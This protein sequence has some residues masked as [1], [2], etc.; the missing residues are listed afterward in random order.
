MDGF[1]NEVR[2]V[3]R[4]EVKARASRT[5]LRDLRARLHDLSAPR[6]FRQ[7]LV[8]TAGTR[9]IA[10]LKKASP[11]GGILREDFD[12]VKIAAIYEEHG[13]SAL[14]ILTDES[15]FKGHLETLT[16][17]RPVTRLRPR[18]RHI[19]RNSRLRKK[20]RAPGIFMRN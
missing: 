1:L 6:P 4:E 20:R 2:R 12:P 11:S 16:D 14:S 3:K 17:L 18:M 9:L 15:F 7:V 10:E 5:P 19:G 8:A 13:A